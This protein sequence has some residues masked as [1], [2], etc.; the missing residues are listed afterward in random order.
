MLLHAELGVEQDAEVA[1]HGRRLDGDCADGHGD[2]LVTKPVES[3]WF[4]EPRQF[5][6]RFI[7]LQSAGRAP[8]SDLG[9]EVA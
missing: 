3:R 6:L 8:A 7:Q 5:F 2:I 9:Y 1:D 4:P